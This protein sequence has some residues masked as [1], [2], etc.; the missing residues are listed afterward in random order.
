MNIKGIAVPDSNSAIIKEPAILDILSREIDKNNK[1]LGHWEQIKKISIIPNE[2]TIEGGELT[3][4]L[5]FKRKIILEKYKKEYH[6][7][8]G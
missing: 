3:P 6:E 1:G 2:L 8:F 4:T 5:K 7:I